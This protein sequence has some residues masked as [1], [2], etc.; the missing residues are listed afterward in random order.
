VICMYLL[1]MECFDLSQKREKGKMRVHHLNNV[2]RALEVLKEQN[3]R[4]VNISNNEIVDGSPKI[5]LALAWTIFLH[6]Q[7]C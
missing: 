6:W 5:T 2:S 1:L 4:L 7:V 3:V